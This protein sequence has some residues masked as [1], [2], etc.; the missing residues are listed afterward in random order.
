MDRKTRDAG[1]AQSPGQLSAWWAFLPTKGQGTHSHVLLPPHCVP[2]LDIGSANGS[3]VRTLVKQ[4][5]DCLTERRRH[6]EVWCEIGPR[7][8]Y[9][10]AVSNA[11]MG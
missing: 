6:D 9:K 10:S 4:R 2:E 1:R 3:G 5:L 11:G 7:L 8:E